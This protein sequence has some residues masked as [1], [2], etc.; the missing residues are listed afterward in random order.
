MSALS[1]ISP[2]QSVLRAAQHLP[3][4]LLGGRSRD[5]P[6]RTTVSPVEGSLNAGR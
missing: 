5:A 3:S 2:D 1:L 6:I 4:V